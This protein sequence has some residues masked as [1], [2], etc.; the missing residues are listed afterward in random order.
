MF[1]VCYTVLA[2]KYSRVNTNP[3]YNIYFLLIFK[4]YR[5]KPQDFKMVETC[6]DF[7]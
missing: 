1:L 7:F 3:N 2:S 4:F 5:R 6:L